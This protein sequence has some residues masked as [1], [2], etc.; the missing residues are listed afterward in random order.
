MATSQAKG[1]RYN[2]VEVAALMKGDPTWST[3]DMEANVQESLRAELVKKRNSKASARRGSRLSA[4][5]T[6][7]VLQSRIDAD[8]TCHIFYSVYIY[9][10]H[11]SYS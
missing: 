10:H 8:V 4:A 9:S 7:W 1:Q 11:Y 5:K 2:I 6:S 3:R